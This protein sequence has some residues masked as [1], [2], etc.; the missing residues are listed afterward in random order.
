VGRTTNLQT[1]RRAFYKPEEIVKEV[2]A[3]VEKTRVIAGAIDYLTF[4][5]DGEPTL[6]INLGRTIDLLKPLGIRTR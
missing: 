3:K 1:D 4:V 6:D 2:V 5:P